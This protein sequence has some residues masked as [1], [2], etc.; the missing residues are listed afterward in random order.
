MHCTPIDRVQCKPW[1]SVGTSQPLA[2]RRSR[3]RETDSTV[4]CRQRAKAAVVRQLVT[5]IA[6][7]RG[8]QAGRNDACA[9]YVT[10]NRGS[11]VVAT[12]VR[13]NPVYAA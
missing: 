3:A 5:W 9:V 1:T 2:L 13:R 8:R 12:T 10:P 4:D 7:D 11:I 6:H